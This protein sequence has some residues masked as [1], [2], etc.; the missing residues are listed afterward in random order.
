MS[1]EL[2]EKMELDEEDWL[3][4]NLPSNPLDPLLYT[5]RCLE[6]HS[7]ERVKQKK[8]LYNREHQA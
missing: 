3:K 1:L 6:I 4:V 8:G 7:L 2:R 5:S